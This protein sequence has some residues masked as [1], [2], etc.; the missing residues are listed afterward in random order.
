LRDPFGIL[1][2][3]LATG[4]PLQMLRIDEQELPLRFQDV[5]PPVSTTPRW[6]PSRCA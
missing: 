5:P 3:G 4:D 2:V 6:L 1:H